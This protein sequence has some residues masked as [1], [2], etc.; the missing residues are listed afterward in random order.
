[1]FYDKKQQKYPDISDLAITAVCKIKL[2]Y[3]KH[4]P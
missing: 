3:K 1:M 4:S 2:G